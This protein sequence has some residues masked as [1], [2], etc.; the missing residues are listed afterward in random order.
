MKVWNLL[1]ILGDLATLLF[2]LLSELAFLTF[3]RFV[4]LAKCFYLGVHVLKRIVLGM[5]LVK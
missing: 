5:F 2:D 4:K 1:V 3:K